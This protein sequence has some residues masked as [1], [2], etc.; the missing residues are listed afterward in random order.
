MLLLPLLLLPLTIAAQQTH[1]SDTADRQFLM[2]PIRI[3][4]TRNVVDSV[5]TSGGWKLTY[6]DDTTLA[7][8]NGNNV[9]SAKLRVSFAKGIVHSLTFSAEFDSIAA[10]A[11]ARMLDEKRNRL[12]AISDSVVVNDPVSTFTRTDSSGAH[13]EVEWSQPDS[14]HLV[15]RCNVD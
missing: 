8:S 11:F 10:T 15:I 5:A 1:A 2:E 13:I 7:Y 4:M 9:S 12:A 3:G 14:R 6:G